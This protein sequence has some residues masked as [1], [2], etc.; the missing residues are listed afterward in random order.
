MTINRIKERIKQILRIPHLQ[1]YLMLKEQDEIVIKLANVK[2]GLEKEIYELFKDD[3]Y[4]SIIIN[5]ELTILNLS[6]YDERNNVL[7][8]Y[9]YVKCPKK[10]AIFKDFDI[11][12]K[13]KNMEVFNFKEDSLSDLYGYIIHIG[14]MENGLLLYKQHYPISLIKRNSFLLSSE[15]AKNRFKKMSSNDIIRLNGTSHLMRIDGEIFIRNLKVL[16]SKLGFDELIIES[17]KNAVNDISKMNLIED[18]EV[19]RDVV[20]DLPYARKLSNVSKISVMK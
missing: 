11:F 4:S 6:E 18:I 8:K 15:K 9:D 5:E 1:I 16:E 20:E 19:L 17:A 14:S 13:T 3:I 10:L 2:D 7:L 12:I